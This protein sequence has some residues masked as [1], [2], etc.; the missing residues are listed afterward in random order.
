MRENF[1][2]LKKNWELSN[3]F[4]F[5]ILLTN[6]LQ[7]FVKKPDKKTNVPLFYKLLYG[8]YKKFLLI[9]PELRND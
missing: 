5:F 7:R 6:I 3:F 8:D 2:V 1:F 4:D 9:L